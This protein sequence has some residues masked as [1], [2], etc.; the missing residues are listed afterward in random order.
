MRLVQRPPLEELVRSTLAVAV[1]RARSG[2]PVSIGFKLKP[3][4]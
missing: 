2:I 3:D 4:L 1:A